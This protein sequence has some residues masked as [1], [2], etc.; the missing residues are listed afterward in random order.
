MKY[1]KLSLF[2]KKSLNIKYII[3]VKSTTEEQRTRASQNMH[4]R[5]ERTRVTQLCGL[6]CTPLLLMLPPPPRPTT[7]PPELGIADRGNK[8]KEN[9]P[10]EAKNLT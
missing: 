9:R 1:L 4:N 3:F 8:G 5:E 6:T 10:E 2:S 7:P